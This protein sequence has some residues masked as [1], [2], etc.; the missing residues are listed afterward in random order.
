MIQDILPKH[1]Y[2]QYEEKSPKADSRVMFFLGNEIHIKGGEMLDF[3]TYAEI[4]AWCRAKGRQLPVWC[5]CLLWRG[6]CIF[7]RKICLYRSLCR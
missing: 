6:R 5:T 7:W 4:E 2:N 1:F 3:P